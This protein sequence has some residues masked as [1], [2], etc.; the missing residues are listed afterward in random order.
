MLTLRALIGAAL[1]TLGRKLFWLFVAA[2]GFLA[3]LDFG[4]RIFQ[5]GPDW[6]ILAVAVGAGLIGALLALFFQSVAIGI[7][8]FVGGGY[9]L[10]SL[11][12]MVGFDAVR[13]NWIVFV[14]GGIIGLILAYALLD[15]ALIV[16]SSLAGA[17]LIVEALNLPT[18]IGLI[19]FVALLVVGILIQA[20]LL[21]K[22]KH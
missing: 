9:V 18:V 6:L 15:W 20:N 8:G 21:H 4:Q 14:V 13:A 22:E 1:L 5:G 2:F 17:A 10:I 3:G 16:L 12:A 11:V 19:A 7:A